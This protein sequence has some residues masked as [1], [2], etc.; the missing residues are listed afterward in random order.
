MSARPGPRLADA[1]AHAGRDWIV[2][3]WPAPARV[4]AFMTTRNGGVSDGRYA[5]LNLSA[6]SAAR[7]GGDRADR[8]AENRAR[9]RALLPADPLWLS[10]VHGT[11]VHVA[12]GDPAA[13][14]PVAD[15]AVTRARNVVLAVQAADCVPVLLADREGGAVAVAHAGWR[16]LAAGVV[17]NAIAAMGIPGG[18]IVAWLGPAIGPHA[19]E[20]G[21]E[22]RDAFLAV[23]PDAASAFRVGRDGKWRADLCGLARQ[24]LARGGVLDVHGG[25]ACTHAQPARFFSHRRDGDTGRMAAFL[26]LS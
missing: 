16:G 20:V 21:A 11:T 13:A 17:E 25:S 4:A 24:R 19:F 9:V 22:V 7:A 1:L 18:N 8:V 2:P 26:W 23:D 10:Q 5:S 6:A 14:P 3:D 12:D 15:A